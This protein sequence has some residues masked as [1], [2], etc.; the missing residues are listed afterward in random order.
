[1]RKYVLSEEIE[2]DWTKWAECGC[3]YAWERLLD[4]IYKMCEGISTH[5]RPKDE[6]EHSDLAHEAFVLTIAKIEDGR[7]TF[8]DRA[9][10][11][12][13]LTTTI[14]R[15]L[16]SLKNR[17]SRRKVAY[18]KL[19]RRTLMDPKVKGQFSTNQLNQ[20]WGSLSMV[21]SGQPSK[22]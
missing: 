5:F 16:Y 7:L 21:D 8:D 13:L 17:D 2:Y 22:K 15:H 6:E 1:M 4:Q 18:G 11:F 20:I 3:Q 19:A 9:P 14:F 10:V 12:N